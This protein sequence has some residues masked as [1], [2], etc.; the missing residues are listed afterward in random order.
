MRTQALRGSYCDNQH[1][2]WDIIYV[3]KYDRLIQYTPWAGPVAIDHVDNA[4]DCTGELQKCLRH[5]M[6]AVAP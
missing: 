4:I 5:P 3:I 1:T 2:M 6:V